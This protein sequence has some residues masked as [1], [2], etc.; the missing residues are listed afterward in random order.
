MPVHYR[1]TDELGFVDCVFV[2]REKRG[3]EKL[4]IVVYSYSPLELSLRNRA[5]DGRFKRNAKLLN[6]EMRI[7]RRL[8]VHPDVRGCG[9]GHY[10]VRKTLPMVGVPYIE[11]LASMGSVNPVFERAGMERIGEC[12]MPAERAKLLRELETLGADPFGADFVNLVVRRPRVRRV[13]AKMIYQWYQA[14]TGE[15]EKRV[16]RQSPQFLA[17]AFR[18]LVGTQPV[19]YLWRRP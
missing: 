19:Y 13:V 6:K 17:Q 8:V 10:L 12:P 4:A 11:C 1:Q 3:G 5:L 18:G 14:T 9:L 7:L 16:A 2:L 15:G